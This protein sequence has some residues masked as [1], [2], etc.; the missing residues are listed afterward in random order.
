[1]KN[2]EE[3]SRI[4]R[5]LK[6]PKG[7]YNAFAKFRYRSCE[8]ILE[9]VKPLLNGCSLTLSDD[10][11]FVG[12]RY[13]VR[14]TATL[15]SDSGEVIAQ[16]TAL[17]REAEIKKGMGDAQI[18]GMASSYARK[19]ALN[20]LLAID[21][22]KDDDS[23]SGQTA[24]KKNAP[25]FVPAN[26]EQIANISTLSKEAGMDDESR[27]TAAKWA[28]GNR[29]KKTCDLSKDEAEKLVTMINKKIQNA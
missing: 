8:D 1:M 21:D 2:I 13:Y 11:I 14:A 19:Y 18:T 10:I 3:L 23:T 24:P 29:A 22:T 28:S 25:E 20:G 5:D 17:A 7:Q 27:E 16:V 9:A 4:Q 26:D 15:L 6:A 12:S